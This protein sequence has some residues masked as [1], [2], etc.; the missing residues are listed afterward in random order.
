MFITI[1]IYAALKVLCSNTL[2]EA[3]DCLKAAIVCNLKLKGSAWLFATLIDLINRMCL[4][5]RM[6]DYGN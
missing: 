3:Q 1:D 6:I 2:F 4:R 5:N